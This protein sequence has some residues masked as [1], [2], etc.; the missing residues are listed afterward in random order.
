M[1]NIGSF[2]NFEAAASAV[3]RFLHSRL[4]FDL[5]MVTRAEGENWIV[6]QADDRGY[7]VRSGTTFRWAD[8][9]CR[10]MVAGEGPCIAPSVESI[11]E[12]AKAPL[13]GK[14]PIGA[15]LGVPLTRSDGTL[16]GTLCAIHPQSLPAGIV[17]ELPMVELCARLLC[18]LLDSDLHAVEQARAADRARAESLIDPLTGLYNRRGWDE[19]CEAE[20]TRC[21]RFGHPA[22]II[23]ADLDGLKGLNDAHGHGAGDDLLRKTAEV[24]RLVI[25]DSDVAARVGGDEFGILCVET[26]TDGALTLVQRL[27][28]TC[29]ETGIEISVGLGAR[30]PSKSL[31]RAIEDADA[32]M[33][34]HKENRR[35]RR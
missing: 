35:A 1:L 14:I 21:K 7:G 20:E 28:R 15:Y 25:R 12:Y 9:F 16:F 26:D 29:A 5:W 11:P 13:A 27:R 24:I 18:S 2:Q 34:R 30:H 22:T 8:T 32:A 3:I 17:H 19:L 23:S 6:L 10:R 4:G 33:Y 31:A